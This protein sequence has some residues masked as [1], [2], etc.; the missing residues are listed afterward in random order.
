MHDWAL[1]ENF[2]KI[3][4]LHLFSLLRRLIRCAI[5]IADS[6]FI[7]FISQQL[8]LYLFASQIFLRYKLFELS[9]E[10][11]D[12]KCVTACID[13]WITDG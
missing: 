1:C 4:P 7:K 11:S 6:L 9:T 5:V 10:L 12:T 13:I 8:F 3:I 2:E